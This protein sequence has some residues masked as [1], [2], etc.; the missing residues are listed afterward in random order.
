MV[1]GSL[2]K[3]ETI[4]NLHSQLKLVFEF[5]QQ[6]DL[7]SYAVGEDKI[8]IDGDNVFCFV[9]ELMARK[10]EDA[11]FESH[12]QYIDI[13]VP[14]KGIEIFGWAGRNECIDVATEYDSKN[15]VIFFNDAVSTYFSVSPENFVVFFP[16]DVHATVIG[17]GTIKKAI[18]KVRV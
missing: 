7:N 18:F 3:T 17:S 13:H 11:A 16:E 5:I 1:I 6:N 8:E 2:T 14:I 15:D 4:A 9:K 10:H 12:N